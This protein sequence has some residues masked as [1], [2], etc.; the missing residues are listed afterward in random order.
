M[1]L[2]STFDQLCAVQAEIATIQSGAQG[3]KIGDISV[4]KAKI[5]ALY[6][7]EETLLTRYNREQRKGS[8]IRPNFSEGA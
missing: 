4:S 1:P 2:I 7:R 5:D 6:A 3:Y 8:R